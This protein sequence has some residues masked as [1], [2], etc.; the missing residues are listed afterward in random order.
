ME[1]EKYL[2]E[3]WRAVAGYKGLYEVSN[4]GRVR[5][6]RRQGS[7]GGLK[8]PSLTKDGYLR[9]NLCKSG[10]HKPCLVHRLVAFAFPE[11]CGEWFEGAE[12][13]HR[14]EVKTDN[15]AENLEFIPHRDNSIYG[16]ANER[17][18]KAVKGTKE[19][20]AISQYDLCGSFI[21][22]WVSSVE[23]EKELGFSSG[24]IVSCCKGRY[25]TMYK[26]IW[27]YAD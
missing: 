25:K 4:Y 2:F 12:V 27:R 22:T 6:Y 14:N 16:T 17:R 11:I 18:S 3:E 20:K 10:K 13:N 15:R 26:Y 8:T 19:T 7:K 9:L 24:N 1:I 23:I 21:K 5:S